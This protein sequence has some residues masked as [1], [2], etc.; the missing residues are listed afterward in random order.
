MKGT[1]WM[2]RRRGGATHCLV[3]PAVTLHNVETFPVGLGLSE[4]LGSAV[5]PALAGVWERRGGVGL[6]RAWV[7][8]QMQTPSWSKRK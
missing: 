7:G 6:P 1:V 8:S 3:C 5:L 2:P 4:K